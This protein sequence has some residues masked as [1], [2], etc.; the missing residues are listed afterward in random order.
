MDWGCSS[1]LEH[2]PIMEQGWW[3]GRSPTP[4]VQ[5]LGDKDKSSSKWHSS[6]FSWMISCLYSRKTRSLCWIE[7][8]VF[9][10]DRKPCWGSFWGLLSATGTIHGISEQATS[11]QHLQGFRTSTPETWLGEILF[12]NEKYWCLA[13]Q[14]VFELKPLTYGLDSKAVGFR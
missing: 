2:S 12:C 13:N 14:I 1:M 10:A 11:K 7:C 5:V 3:K 4:K 8:P 9:P 6:N